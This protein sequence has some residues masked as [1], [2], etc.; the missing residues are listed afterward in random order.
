MYRLFIITK[1]CLLVTCALFL[2]HFLCFSSLLGPLNCKIIEIN[3]K[4]CNLYWF[5]GLSVKLV[6]FFPFFFHCHII[7]CS[8]DYLLRSKIEVIFSLKRSLFLVNFSTKNKSLKIGEEK[9]SREEV[10][11]I[12][13]IL[14]KI[15][16]DLTSPPPC[17]CWC[18]LQHPIVSTRIH[19]LNRQIGWTGLQRI[20]RESHATLQTVNN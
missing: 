16:L 10:N 1:S 7:L 6:V 5:Y 13:K 9:R 19:Q 15:P 18:W 8:N 4:L 2:L 20:P 12:L 11:W 17:L 3:E 14:Y